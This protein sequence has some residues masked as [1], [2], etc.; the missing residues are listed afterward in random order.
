MDRHDNSLLLDADD[1]YTDSKNDGHKHCQHIYGTSDGQF[2]NTIHSAGGQ[3]RPDQVQI[4][5]CITQR[6]QR[7]DCNDYGVSTAG[8]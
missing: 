4:L 2:W 1:I 7:Q 8:Q 3:R 5:R 6:T